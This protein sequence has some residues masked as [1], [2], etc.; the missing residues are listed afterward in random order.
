MIKISVEKAKELHLFISEMTGG[1]PGIRDEALLESALLA[2]FATFGGEELYPTLIEKA[3]RLCH[4]LIANHAFVDGNKRI[5]M[6]A[7]LIFLE[8]NGIQ[9]TITTDEVEYLGLALASGEM[10]YEGLVEFL[11][12]RIA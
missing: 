1:D 12:S 4:S 8:A 5:G 2:P 11:S 7:F 6:F 10:K 3:C 9:T